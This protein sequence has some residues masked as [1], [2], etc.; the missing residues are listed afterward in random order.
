MGEIA[1]DVLTAQKDRGKMNQL[2]ANYLPFIKKQ[3]SRLR[4]I[5][6]EYD[7]MLSLAML[8]FSGCVQQ[9]AVDKGNF[10]AFCSVS[11]RNRLIDES[12]KQ[13]R[14]ENKIVPLFANEDEKSAC[15]AGAEASIAAYNM[16]QEQNSLMQEIEAFALELKDFGIDFNDLPRVCPKQA[17]SRELCI[18]LAS[19]IVANPVLYCELKTTHRIAQKSLSVRFAVSPKTLDKHRKYLIALVVLLSGDYPYIQ[20][21]L[22]NARR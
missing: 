15:M 16:E 9:Y 4:G 14:Y 7:D 8:T 1:D 17:R 11:I 13:A 18:R 20:A 2:I 12:R 19:E 6:M 5:H 22:P 3:L 21:F 10:L